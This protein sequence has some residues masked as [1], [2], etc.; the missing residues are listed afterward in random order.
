MK[1]KGGLRQKNTNI[2]SF[3][4]VLNMIETP[5]AELTHVSYKSASG[6]IFK[7]DIPKDPAKSE[8]FGLN[9][10][11]HEFNVPIYSL[12]FKFAVIS[13]NTYDILPSLIIDS[14]LYQKSCET[15]E[16]FKKESEVQQHI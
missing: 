16:D 15:L 4:A 11:T 13:D 5:G 7:L 14:K 3:Q 10:E 9:E 8:F 12:I 1:I 2:S 6:F